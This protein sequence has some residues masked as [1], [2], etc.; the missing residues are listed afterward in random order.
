DWF[1]TLGYVSGPMQQLIVGAA[2]NLRWRRLVLKS[3]SRLV[4]QQVGTP[5][6]AFYDPNWDITFPN[7]GLICVNDVDAL[8]QVVPGLRAGAR[9]DLTHAFGGQTTQRLGRLIS[10]MFFERERA[11]FNAPTLSLVVNWWLEHPSR[12]GPVPFVGLAFTFRS[13]LS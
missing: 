9:Y 12:V 5:A 3:N 6:A 10:Y 11:A 1:G 13:D 4:F 2:L 8:V 7:G